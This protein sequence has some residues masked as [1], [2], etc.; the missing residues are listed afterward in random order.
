MVDLGPMGCRELSTFMGSLG[1][2]WRPSQAAS[3]ASPP[4]VRANLAEVAAV[5]LVFEYSFGKMTG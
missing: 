2:G 4:E 5:H 3:W 1:Y